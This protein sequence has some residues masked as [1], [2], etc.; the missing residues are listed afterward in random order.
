LRL[1]SSCSSFPKRESPKINP[2]SV[3]CF[4]GQNKDHQLTTN[5]PRFTTNSPSKNH[6]MSQ[7]FSKTPCKNAKN[8][9]GKKPR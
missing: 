2:E 9:P 1:H 5:A 4:S 6:K 7:G 8:H 3:A